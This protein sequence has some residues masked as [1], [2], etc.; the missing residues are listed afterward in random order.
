M[1]FLFFE[2]HLI[3]FKEKALTKLLIPKTCLQGNP[4]LDK[5]IEQ[6]AIKI[7]GRN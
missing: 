5:L 7:Q 2:K 3:Y 1:D 6:K 4:F